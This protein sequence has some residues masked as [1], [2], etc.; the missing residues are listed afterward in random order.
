[1]TLRNLLSRKVRLAL[2]AFAVVLGVAFVAG[3]FVFTD[4][5]GTSFDSIIRGSTADVEIAPR[6][7]QSFGAA[8][9]VRLVPDTVVQRL[10][11]L[12]GAAAVHPSLR[13]DSVYVIGR[14][15]KV[16]GGNGPPGLGLSYSG[17]RNIAG[18]P[19]IT[20]SA[21]RLP[22]APY[23][24]ALDAD[25]AR[26]A[27][28]RLGD[29]VPLATAATPPTMHARLVGLVSFAGGGLGGASLT[30]FDTAF[31]HDHFFHG[32]DGWSSVTLQAAPG[33]SQR[34]LAAA[35]QRVL[36]SGFVARTGDSVVKANQADLDRVLGFL[37]TFLLVFAAISL[38]VGTF[39]IV[40]T[41]SILVAQRSRELALLR[42][43]GASRGQ[44]NRSVLLEAAVVGVVGS[45]VGLG[46][47]YLLALG[48]RGLFRAFGLD[49]GNAAL[50]VHPRTVL[51]SYAVGLLVTVAA[52]Y[53]PAR[54]AGSV[55]PVAAL[56]DDV[57]LPESSL[58]RRLVAGAVLVVGGAAAMAGGFSRGG[59]PGLI[60]L[61]VGMLAILVGVA[62]VSPWLGRPVTAVFAT[63][64]RR[65][66]GTVGLL[67]AQNSLRNP[68]RTAA[69]A[70]ALMV[71]LTL[72]TL[73]SVLGRSAQA[74][75]D[76]AVQG[77]LSSQLVVSNV[78]GSPFSPAVAREVRKVAGVQQVVQF[79]TAFGSVKGGPAFVGAVDPRRLGLAVA[80]PVERGSLAALGPGTVAVG[81]RA[82]AR[83]GYRVGDTVPLR[84]QA[85]V[86][87][88]RVVALFASSPVLPGNYLVTPATLRQGG[89]APRDSMLFVTTTGAD[90]GAVQ[91]RVERV[92][93]DLPTVTVKTPGQYADEQKAQIDTFLYFI[94]ALLGLAV[95]IAVLGIVNTLALSVI[96]RTREV[97]L[98][99]AVGLS[100]AQLRRMVRLEAVIVA[101]LGAVLGVA[102]GLA[103][104]VALQ[105]LL[106][107]R[108]VDVLAV[109]WS[110]LAVF[111]AL[112]AVAGVLA[113]V[114]PA[115][116]AARLD[117]LRAIGTE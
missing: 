19:I 55:A 54:R 102:L 103:F 98:L 106:T 68:R 2:S 1:M 44:V 111:V 18:R 31:M 13:A 6:G 36:P 46:V 33:V 71:G 90:A 9:D 24:I 93:A 94:Y 52:A 99:R 20:L 109:P 10:R 101:V 59:D 100:R 87:R 116:R 67:A 92:L 89:L 27:G 97:G 110:M 14:Q 48:L 69:T 105:R 70:S 40:N 26:K 3:S 51:A 62:S 108:G 117:V 104:G 11:A 65:V 7:S 12:P 75:T 74:S 96:E 43:L 84:L 15:G 107:D 78:V 39:L 5:M 29:R 16:I 50:A 47:G 56:R 30:V 86:Q 42:A 17:A 76:K 45:T 37:T 85:G 35:A 53:V 63:G 25:T 114:L 83:H 80:L 82:A 22:R 79:R 91:S 38:V 66:F 57:A 8:Q 64:Y 61:G 23:Q 60:L 49:L 73:M 34:R 81:S 4:A 95:V 77:T 58:R 112:S 88:L 32:A 115:R 21:G 72:V 113:A 28:Y 41:F